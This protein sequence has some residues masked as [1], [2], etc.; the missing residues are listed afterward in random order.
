MRSPPLA[1]PS[2]CCSPSNIA[3]LVL[4]FSHWSH[5]IMLDVYPAIN[6]KQKERESVELYRFVFLLYSGSMRP[7]WQLQR[8][9]RLLLEEDEW[10]ITWTHCICIYTA[11]HAFRIAAIR[12]GKLLLY[13]GIMS[14]AIVV[15]CARGS[16]AALMVR[17]KCNQS[18]SRPSLLFKKKRLCVIITF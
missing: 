10:C 2:W 8:I 11:C 14:I 4:I 17:K 18:D 12:V 6:T 3:P 13:I 9:D 7:V 1:A 5:L 15:R 16:A